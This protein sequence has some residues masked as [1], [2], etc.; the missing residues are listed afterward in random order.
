M[1]R[2]KVML[3]IPIALTGFAGCNS[4]NQT[5]EVEVT[6]RNDSQDTISMKVFFES[7]NNIFSVDYT[8]GPTVADESEEFDFV[9]D[10]IYV[11]VNGNKAKI[12]TFDGQP[13]EGTR[14]IPVGIVYTESEEIEVGF[15]C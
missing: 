7:N 11:I 6:A 14:S 13:C 9:P 8:L 12:S 2:R 10:M 5:N 15:A 3:S 4:M 1:L